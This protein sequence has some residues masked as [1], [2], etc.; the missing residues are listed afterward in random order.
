ML[1]SSLADERHRY[2]REFAW[3][4]I[5]NAARKKKMLLM[6]ISDVLEI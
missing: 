4:Q 1:I 2:K 3:V 6:A 5:W